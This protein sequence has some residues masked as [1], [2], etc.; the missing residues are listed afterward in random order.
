MESRELRIGCAGAP[1]AIFQANDIVQLGGRYLD[2]IGVD[3]RDHAVAQARLDVKRLLR[4]KLGGGQRIAAF[5]VFEAQAAVKDH[6]RLVLAVVILQR[7][8]FPRLDVQDLADVARRLCPDQLMSPGFGHG[9]H[10][11]CVSQAFPSDNFVERSECK[12]R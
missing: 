8:L 2:D 7:K 3:K 10:S 4:P 5:G 1:V 9:A 11:F 12:A 6:D